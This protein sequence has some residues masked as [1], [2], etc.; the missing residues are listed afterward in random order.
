M[1]KDKK[2]ISEDK[3]Y[4]QIVEY[5][6]ITDEFSLPYLSKHN[7]KPY[8]NIQIDELKRSIHE[9]DQQVKGKIC[10][11]LD[12]AEQEM[13]RSLDEF[14]G[15]GGSKD[16]ENHK[17]QNIVVDDQTLRAGK[18]G[19]SGLKE[20]SWLIDSF[21]RR[22]TEPNI[23]R[24]KHDLGYFIKTDDKSLEKID[25]TLKIEDLKPIHSKGCYL[26][27]SGHELSLE[28]NR[29]HLK[30]NLSKNKNFLEEFGYKK[31]P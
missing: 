20:D 5:Y 29:S 7:S 15:L 30:S 1:G 11:V 31:S 22:R 4:K 21:S 18:T 28:S 13:T 6:G 3:K 17:Q 10:D 16:F 26:K 25:D 23:Y 19:F 12:Q 9:T 14:S 27:A 8:S 2:H 24:S